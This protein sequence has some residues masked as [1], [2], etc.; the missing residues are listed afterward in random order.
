MK[1]KSWYIKKLSQKVTYTNKVRIM[2]SQDRAVSKIPNS[3]FTKNEKNVQNGIYKI[4][5]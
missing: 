4:Y 1:K 2:Q 3:T 5:T